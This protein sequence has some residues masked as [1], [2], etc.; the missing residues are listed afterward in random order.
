MDAPG[1]AV[2]ELDQRGAGA[3]AAHGPDVVAGE[4]ADGVECTPLHRGR[5]DHGP[6]R[7][8]EVL[9]QRARGLRAD[10]PDVGGGDRRDRDRGSTPRPSGW[11]RRWKL[12][13]G[14]VADATTVTVSAAEVLPT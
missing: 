3:V 5:G 11:S 8:V 7:A 13:E 12:A 1:C 14:G 6:G 4:G 10:G 9:D 2:E